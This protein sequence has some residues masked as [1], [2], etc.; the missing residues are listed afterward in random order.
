[1]PLVTRKGAPKLLDL[2]CGV[3][4]CSMGYHLAGFDVTGIDLNPQPNYPFKFFRRDAMAVSLEG[5]DCYHASPPC[6]RYSLMSKGTTGRSEEHPDLIGAIRQRLI[7]TGKSYCI[8]NVPSSPLLEPVLLCGTRFTE[9]EVVRHRL[10]ET[11]FWVRRL[12][13]AT[14]PRVHQGRGTWESRGEKDYLMV[15]GHCGNV[16]QARKAMGIYWAE[17]L[18][19]VVEAIPPVYTRYLGKFLMDALHQKRDYSR[20]QPEWINA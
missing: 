16:E 1:M 12:P 13:C 9:L 18:S 2:F 3:G 8:E 4:G 10:F 15:V 14:H 6:Q 5:Y 11:S 19:E 7:E 20:W 17:K